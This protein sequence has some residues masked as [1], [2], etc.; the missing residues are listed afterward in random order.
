MSDSQWFSS[1]E[2]QG[3]GVTYY[4]YSYAASERWPVRVWGQVN[5][6]WRLMCLEVAD[7]V[8]VDVDV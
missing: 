5:V 8:Y 1:D 2:S 4:W 6:C 3:E 7:D